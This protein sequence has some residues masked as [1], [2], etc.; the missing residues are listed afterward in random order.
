MGDRS[1][2][3]ATARALVAVL[4]LGALAACGPTIQTTSG[5]AYIGNYT[6]PTQDK[7]AKFSTK[8]REAALV[9]PTL[10]FPARIGLARVE[11]GRLTAIPPK[12]A[13]AWLKTTKN[14]GARFG[15]FVPISPLVAALAA[16]D[17][18]HPK[19]KRRYYR[20]PADLDN[21]IQRIRIGAAR[22]H[23]D[24][25]L[26]YEVIGKKRQSG[27]ALNLADLTIIGAYLFPSR[28][29]KAQGFAS[30]VLVDVRNG[31]PYGTAQATTKNGGLAPP[32]W[33][34]EGAILLEQRSKE[35]AVKLLAGDV[36]KMM[37][38]LYVELPGQRARP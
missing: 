3:T 30:A 6:P 31:Y 34:N 28:A 35:E 7:A 10:E 12:E 23:V 24:A 18:G 14:L 20:Q 22:Q 1:M 19:P 36:E 4:A 13:D 26:I 32:V 16:G 38:R 25:V 33:S 27:T 2:I 9:E 11:G 17:V 29:I 15:E 21:L 8:I 5:A 37:E